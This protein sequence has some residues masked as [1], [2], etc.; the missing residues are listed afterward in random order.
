M[1]GGCQLSSTSR[2]RPPVEVAMRTLRPG[3]WSVPWPNLAIKIL[4]QCAIGKVSEELLLLVRDVV[5]EEDT[6]L[7]LAVNALGFL[8]LKLRLRGLDLELL[9]LNFVAVLFRRMRTT[10][11]SL[12]QEFYFH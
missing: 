2:V 6:T 8:V 1:L 12:P 7:Q 5:L 4:Q 3:I 9:P 11:E 10:A